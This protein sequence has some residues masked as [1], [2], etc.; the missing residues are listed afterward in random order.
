[1]IIKQF[2][3]VGDIRRECEK[4]IKRNFVDLKLSVSFMNNFHLH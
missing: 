2:Y 1:M 4:K 3:L